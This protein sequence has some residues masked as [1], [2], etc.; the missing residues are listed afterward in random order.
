MQPIPTLLTTLL[1]LPLVLPGQ[2]QVQ[3]EGGGVTSRKGEG[4]VLWAGFP[5]RSDPFQEPPGSGRE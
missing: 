5:H 1:L 2:P 3:V 4:S